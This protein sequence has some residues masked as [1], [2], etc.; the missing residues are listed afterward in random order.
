MPKD[1]NI[2]RHIAKIEKQADEILENASAQAE[3]IRQ[4]AE[5]EAAR[6][7]RKTKSEIE[8]AKTKLAKDYKGKT[9]QALRQ[10]EAQ[11][12]KEKKSLAERRDRHFHELVEWTASRI[13]ER[14]AELNTNGD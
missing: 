6:L 10:I 9:E 12:A 8:Q 3:K 11:F 1:D 4:E 2:L 7:A 13:R 5:S 14:Q